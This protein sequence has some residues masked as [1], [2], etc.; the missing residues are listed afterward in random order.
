MAPSATS[1]LIREFAPA[2]R[3]FL[4]RAL[5]ADLRDVRPF[6]PLQMFLPAENWGRTYST[7]ILRA[8]RKHGGCLLVAEVGRARAGF[9]VGVLESVA[10]GHR[11]TFAAQRPGWVWDLY[12]APK[13]RRRGVGTALLQAIEDY[14]RGAH[15]DFVHLLALSGNDRAVAM[16]RR[17]GYVSRV[18]MLGKWLRDPR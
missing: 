10:P 11:R 9:V 14:F 16:Y 2:D 8:V 12:V 15:R 4:E 17:R 7:Q 18:L 5:E 1:L 6:D 3:S 13:Y